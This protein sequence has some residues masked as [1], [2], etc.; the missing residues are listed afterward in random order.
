MTVKQS[1]KKLSDLCRTE[2]NIF[3]YTGSI[4]GQAMKIP[5][6]SSWLAFVNLHIIKL[7]FEGAWTRIAKGYQCYQWEP[8]IMKQEH[9]F[10]M[11]QQ[12]SLINLESHG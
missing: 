4:W 11:D 1:L 12:T 6:I 5:T 2:E 10:T 9:L 3:T 8:W 7:I